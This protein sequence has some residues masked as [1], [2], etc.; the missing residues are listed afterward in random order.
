MHAE[1]TPRHLI[2]PCSSVHVALS[3]VFMP[4]VFVYTFIRAH[5]LSKYL[6][7]PKNLMISGGDAGNIDPMHHGIPQSK[8]R[9]CQ[10]LTLAVFFP[11]PENLKRTTRPPELTL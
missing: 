6:L 10:P 2:R 3:T 8:P 11:S 1:H 4:L 7:L 9:S 5:I